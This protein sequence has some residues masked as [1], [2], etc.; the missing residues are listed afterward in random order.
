MAKKTLILD[1]ETKAKILAGES[2]IELEVGEP[3]PAPA[4]GTAPATAPTA[5]TAPAAAPA[6]PAAADA[7]VVAFL[8]GEIAKKDQ[9]LTEA[10]VKIAQLEASSKDN[11]EALPGLLAIAQGA[12]ANMQIALGG[13]DTSKVFTAKDAVAEH[14]RLE[15]LYK[16]KFKPGGLA[17]PSAEDTQPSVKVSQEFLERRAAIQANAK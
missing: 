4:A 5:P 17:A 7:G 11:A 15:P 14:A 3:S 2:T 13:S 9:A 6:A 16:A 10:A 8:T 1:P 12:I